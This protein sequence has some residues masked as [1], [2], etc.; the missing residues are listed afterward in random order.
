MKPLKYLFE[1]YPHGEDGTPEYVEVLAHNSNDAHRN[2][3]LSY[4]EAYVINRFVQ[5]WRVT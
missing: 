3:M 5:D 4:P 2:L 1:I